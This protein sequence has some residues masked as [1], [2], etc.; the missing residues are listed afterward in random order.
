M[1]EWHR[2]PPRRSRGGVGNVDARPQLESRRTRGGFTL[3]D[4]LVSLGV[5]GVLIAIL[6]PSL[7]QVNETARRVVCRSNVRQIGLCAAMYAGEND[8]R[9]PVSIFL[10][11]S[12]VTVNPNWGTRSL[13]GQVHRMATLH[14]ASA[15]L[16]DAGVNAWDG[17]GRLYDTGFVT[18][19]KVFYCP[20][21]RGA[22]HFS[23]QAASWGSVSA[24]IVGNYQYRGMGRIAPNRDEMTNVLDRI[25]G[26]SALI[27]DGLTTQSDNNHG[28]GANIFR[29]D[30]SVLWRS[31]TDRRVQE[32]L[33]KE[34]EEA[35]S[36]AVQEAWAIYD[37][38]VP[39]VSR[40]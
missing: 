27:A 28:V 20:S 29:A 40:R 23:V 15:E 14:L 36:G 4:V 8:G 22:N 35:N 10:P 24:E 13:A 34:K 19:P 18:A 32:I 12:V 33:P 7:S 31:D 26:L 37:E 38:P 9:L 21:H 30:L 1:S 17:L 3:I 39:D 16:P 2:S 6:L 25:D 11:A 5:I